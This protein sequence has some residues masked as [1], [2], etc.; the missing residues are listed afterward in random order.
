MLNNIQH[1]YK[2]FWGKNMKV[3]LTIFLS[4][5]FALTAFGQQNVG[6]VAESFN[7]TTLEGKDFFLDDHRG[8]VVVMTFW[9]TKCVICHEEIPKLNKLTSKYQGKDVVFMGLTMENETRVSLYLEKKPFS[10]TIV[11]NS[12][13]VILKYA[14]RDNQGNPNMGFPAYF[15]ISPTGELTYKSYG[16]DKTGKIDSEINKL[17]SNAALKT[18]TPSNSTA[19]ASVKTN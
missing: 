18:S 10:F 12:L 9:S 19:V 1:R 15:V 6:S 16:W 5:L 14:D 2:I 7:G 8:K 13:G 3:V 4:L 17:L 11:P